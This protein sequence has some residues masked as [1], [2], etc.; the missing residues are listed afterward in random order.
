MEL[1]L[2]KNQVSLLTVLAVAALL[3]GMLL[4]QRLW[5]RLDLTQD[6]SQSVSSISRRLY[7]ELEHTLTITYYVSRTLARAHSMPGTIEDLL[8]EFAAHSRGRIRVQ[9]KDP[10]G[11]AAMVERLGLIPQQIP[12]FRKDQA[13]EVTVYTGIVMEYADR[14]DTIPVVFSLDNLEYD[15]YARVKALVSGTFRDVGVLVADADKSWAS[16][17]I[18][19]AQG[20]ELAGYRIREI[21]L[22]ESIP[23]N[24]SALFVFGGVEELYGSALGRVEEYIRSGGPVLFAVG[25]VFVDSGAVLA[26]RTMQDRGLLSLLSAYGVSIADGLVLDTSSL[27]I[28]IQIQDP[29]GA[30]RVSLVRYPHW[31]AVLDTGEGR[32]HP[33]TSRFGGVDMFWPSPLSLHPPDGIRADILITSSP[34]SWR[35]GE[36]F[37]TDPQVL[38]SLPEPAD[39]DLAPSVLAVALS[40]SFHGNG[41]PNRMVVVGNS[42]LATT[43]IQYTQSERNIDFLL[44]CADWLAGNEEMLGMRKKSPRPGRLDSIADPAARERTIFFIR[45]LNMVVLPLA[46]AFYGAIRIYRRKRHAQNIGRDAIG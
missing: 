45:M 22:G 7:L 11:Q 32:D 8:R 34:S 27:A 28:P 43:L 2:T 25:G 1:G 38:S 18:Y 23:P 29:G 26:A 46:V 42:A 14:T 3:L 36:P 31:I 20:F 12:A 9:V 6:S 16:D 41:T 21:S 33:I 15:L 30:S 40:G 44:R 4:S 10:D 39:A 24:L 35:M 19:L 13:G 17:F 37:I 5:F